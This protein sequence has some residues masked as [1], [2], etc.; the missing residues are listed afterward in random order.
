MGVCLLLYYRN[1]DITDEYKI[2]DRVN[3][4]GVNNF[5]S[6]T[7]EYDVWIN[8]CNNQTERNLLNYKLE[9]DIFDLD[10]LY[11]IENDLEAYN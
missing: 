6:A 11:D 10:D 8:S 7:D 4:I 1:M 3:F 2:D 5:I 9:N